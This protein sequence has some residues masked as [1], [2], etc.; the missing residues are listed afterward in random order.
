MN[1][2]N[3]IIDK[4][5]GRD[6]LLYDGGEDAVHVLNPSARLIYRLYREGRDEAA[7]KDRLQKEF[8]IAKDRDIE[9][10]IRRTIEEMRKKGLV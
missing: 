8:A 2:N 1:H 4:P 10:D 6:L 7:I 5:M 9:G 3:P